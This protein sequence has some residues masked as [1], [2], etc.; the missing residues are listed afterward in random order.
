MVQNATKNRLNFIEKKAIL[1]MRYD[2]LVRIAAYAVSPSTA[3]K[4]AAELDWG[5]KKSLSCRYLAM[6]LRDYG[7]ESFEAFIQDNNSDV[8]E[9]VCLCGCHIQECTGE[10][11]KEGLLY[12]TNDDEDEDYCDNCNCA[13]DN[14]YH[15][16]HTFDYECP[17]CDEENDEYGDEETDEET[18]EDE[19]MSDDNESNDG[20]EDDDDSDED[21]ENSD[22][23]NSDDDYTGED[24]SDE[25]AED[26]D[27]EEYE[28][29]EDRINRISRKLQRVAGTNYPVEIIEDSA[30]NAY[31]NGACVMI[32]TGALE[33]LNDD[34][35]AFVLGH[36][37]A[38]NE[39]NHPM[40][41]LRRTAKVLGAITEVVSES[42]G[43]IRKVVGGVAMGAAGLAITRLADRFGEYTADE[44]GQEI[45][46]QA[47]YDSDAGAEA[48]DKIARGGGGGVFGTHP[49]TYRRIDELN[50]R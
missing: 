20:A 16:S 25:Y 32:T 41:S 22:E 13:N 18:S 10:D 26:R 43:I 2:D 12:E 14:C 45:A 5:Q 37:I 7:Q 38:H 39:C 36:E 31:A 6:L 11:L 29:N 40:S 46:E 15:A 1:A 24:E 27:E 17:T 3:F 35:I 44:L 9:S 19:Y 30:P 28:D 33:S 4:A 34:E 8:Y 47:G 48:L 23:E 21:D 50:N 42:K 49:K